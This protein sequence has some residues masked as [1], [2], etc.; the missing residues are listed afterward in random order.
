MTDY[1]QALPARWS[2]AVT[3]TRGQ[4]IGLLAC[5]LVLSTSLVLATDKTLTA[6]VVVVNL[7]YLAST[8]DKTYLLH[9][10]MTKSVAVRV[11]DERALAVP[12]DEL[13]HY[14]VLLPVFDEPEIVRTLMDGVG[15]LNYPS[16]KLDILL[17]LEADDSATIEAFEQGHVGGV[18]PVLVPPSEPRTKPKACNYGMSLELERSEYATIYDA[19]DIPDPL[20]LRR[21]AVM[22]AE[23]PSEVACIQ[24]RLGYFNEKQNILTKW[25]AM[26]YDQWFTYMLPALAR[27]K[28]VIPLGGTSNHF[29]SSVWREL[30]GWD[31][32]NVTEDADLGIRLARHG[33]RTALMDSVT[34]EEAN[35]D[36]VNWIRQRSRWYKG[37]LQT[38]LVHFRSPRELVREIGL[39][40]TLRFANTTLGMPLSNVI[41]LIFWSSV[42]FWYVGH[43]AIME[44]LLPGAIYYVSL[45][46]FTLGN[47]VTLM[48]GLIST[49]ATDKPYLLLAAL[50]V[51]AYWVM[52]GLAAVKG[53]FQLFFRA[54]YWEKTVHGLS[55]NGEG[56]K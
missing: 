26:E 18:T 10:G 44:T 52:Q 32:F 36:P 34:L 53:L 46:L 40:S 23:S 16:D 48:L 43:P 41:N 49:R 28:C 45:L 9:L 8:I 56:N 13:P 51:P 39:V 15:R 27:R 21:A 38:F 3:F 50:T 35:S 25:F 22:F 1:T 42:L 17:L 33:Y 47:V 5:A 31:S 19:E 4:V 24:A 55:D 7:Y 54:S 6:I 20:Q 29:R 11:S 30:G 14:T 12:D 2:A 37:Y